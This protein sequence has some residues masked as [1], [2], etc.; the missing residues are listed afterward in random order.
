MSWLYSQALVAAYSEDICS[1]GEPSALLSGNPTQ[2]A[3]LP[4]DKM[5][6]FSRLSRFGMTFKPLTATLGEEL[7]MW[8]LAGFRAKTSVQREI[9]PE[10]T[11][12][13]QACGTTWRELLAKF[14]P[15]TFMWKIPQC[16][17]LEDLA[18]FSG[19]WPRW[20]LMQNGVSYR[21]QTLVHRIK[22][23]EFGLWPTPTAAE[24]SKIPATANYGQIG[25]NNHPRIRG[26]VTRP[27]QVKSRKLPTPTMCGNYNRKGLSAT[28]GDGLA[29][30][31]K[32]WPT[33]TAHN[34]KEG[35]YP[36][37]FTLNTP[38]LN[39]VAI[40]GPQIQRMPLNPTWVEWLMGWPL[41]WTDLRPLEM[42]KYQQWLQQ[43][44]VY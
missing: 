2:L 15:N 43:H 17:L 44:G 31:V 9:E 35:G 38:T 21:Q 23:T 14:D 11:A 12:K 1:D 34:S 20:G 41:G 32:N 22:E 29:T 33:P 27:K 40:G 3:Y 6:K 4:P 10:L 7:L 26:A 39:A 28:S 42:D 25:L 16:S 19:T 37:E 36:A 8:Y 18:E 24:G 13:N 5:T 30:M